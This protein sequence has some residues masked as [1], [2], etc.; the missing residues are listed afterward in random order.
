MAKKKPKQKRRAAAA[1]ELTQ[2]EAREELLA[3]EAIF[4]EDITPVH[5][6]QNGS[7]GFAL[8]VVPHPGEALANHVA[9]TLVVRCVSGRAHRTPPCS[10]AAATCRRLPPPAR[11]RVFNQPLP[12]PAAS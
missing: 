3:L 11:Q 9:V 1:A 7:L 6:N 12:L 2:E 4:A 8:H 5:N 10:A